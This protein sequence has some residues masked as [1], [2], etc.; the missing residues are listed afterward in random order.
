MAWKLRRPPEVGR[1]VKLLLRLLIN[2]A[3][4]WV[5]VRIVPGIVYHGGPLPLLG[6]ALVFG[7][8]NSFVKPIVQLFSLP[9]VVLTL[10]LFLLVVNALMLWLTS[11]LSAALG[12]G[13]HVEGFLPAFLGAIA[14]SVVSMLLS[15]FVAAE[16]RRG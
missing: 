3:A 1:P 15:G 7:L 11:A 2:A 12:L 5:A 14:V 6:V 16:S 9:F 10:G 8:V 4:L 13:F